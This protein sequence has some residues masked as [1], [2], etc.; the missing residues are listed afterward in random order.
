[1]TFFIILETLPF[2]MELRIF[3]IDTMQEVST[4][5]DTMR[6]M[7]PAAGSDIPVFANMKSCQLPGINIS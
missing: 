5:S 6:R 7:V 4:T 2:I 3:T 1:M